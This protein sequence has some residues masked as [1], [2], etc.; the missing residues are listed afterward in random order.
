[1]LDNGVEPSLLATNARTKY[2]HKRCLESNCR[3]GWQYPMKDVLDLSRCNKTQKKSNNP[4]QV[5][6]NQY[7]QNRHTCC[8]T[9]R[10]KK[11]QKYD[12]YR[13]AKEDERE[14][15]PYG[16]CMNQATGMIAL[17][18]NHPLQLAC[19]RA[20]LHNCVDATQEGRG[21]MIQGT[22]KALSWEWKI[23]AENDNKK[24]QCT[25]ALRSCQPSEKEEFMKLGNI[26]EQKPF[27][28]HLKNLWEDSLIVHTLTSK[29]PYRQACIPNF[30]I[31]PQWKPV[32]TW[33]RWWSMCRDHRNLYF[34]SDRIEDRS[35]RRELEKKETLGSSPWRENLV[36][37]N[38][39]KNPQKM[40]RGSSST[41]TH[42][43]L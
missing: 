1:V 23:A 25:G 24:L 8:C 20:C 42:I 41:R 5:K 21:P 12:H 14:Y 10:W 7:L 9:V 32:C 2:E 15:P 35:T 38:T 19:L 6:S 27:T 30:A 22:T 37:E 13:I 17:I 16:S 26:H 3:R 4:E 29:T 18:I 34:I 36:K 43:H 28:S 11:S 31:N 40:W 33:C 39:E